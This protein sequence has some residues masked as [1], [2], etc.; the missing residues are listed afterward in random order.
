MKHYTYKTKGTCSRQISFDSDGERVYNIEFL[1]GCPGN[2]HG[3]AA[4][5]DG[6]KISEI[7]E[8]FSSIDCGGR[9]TSCPAELAKAVQQAVMEK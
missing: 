8:K 6:L 3:I 1:M 2:T 7:T 9:G 5:C 4:I